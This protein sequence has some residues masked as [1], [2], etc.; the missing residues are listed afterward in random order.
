[1]NIRQTTLSTAVALAVLFQALISYELYRVYQ[2]KNKSK[3]INTGI[4]ASSIL[5]KAIIEMSL[6]RSVMQVT[7]NLDDPIAPEFRDLLNGQREKSDAGFDEVDA[8][9]SQSE[10]FRRQDEFLSSLRELR[11]SIE[12]IREQADAALGKTRQQ[13]SPQKINNL[14]N[15]MKGTIL[16]LSVLPLKLRPEDANVPTLVTTLEKIQRDAWA[17][18][19]FGGRERTYFA[20]ATATGRTFTPDTLKEMSNYHSKALT[21]M[22]SLALLGNYVGI[23][24]ELKSQIQKV[25]DVYF[26]SYNDVRMA[27]LQ[28][29]SL[30]AP[31]SSSF[32]DFF[33]V[34][35]EALDTAVNLSYMAGDEMEAYVETQAD[36]STQLFWVFVLILVAALA[37]CG[38]QIYITQY[39]VSNRI[40]KLASFM[41]RLTA[42][43]TDIDLSSVQAKDEIGEMADHVEVFRKNAIEVQRLEQEKAAQEQKAQEEKKQ[44]ATDLANRF[45]QEVGAIVQSVQNAATNMNDMSSNLTI[46]I[47]EASKQSASVAS[48][49]QETSTN[50]QTVASAAEEMSVSIREISSSIAETAAKAQQCSKSAELSQEQLQ[51]L[52]AAVDEID[53]VIQ[54]INDVAEQTNLLALN[55]TIEAARAGEAGKGFAVVASEVKSLANETHKM[56]EEISK[57]VETIK[58]TAS[59]T[60]QSVT[61]IIEEINAVDEKTSSIAAAIEQQSSATGEISS[62]AAQ[63][64]SGTSNVSQNIEE[65]QKATN[66]SAESTEQ[67]QSASHD[68]SSQASN[69]KTAVDGFLKSIRN[70]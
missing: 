60:I 44:S 18:R 19:E 7:L 35:T 43:D 20:I 58:D 26:G 47:Q 48:A 25:Q 59:H 21:A 8:L 29:S 30:G 15:N 41:K 39:R 67:L 66:E 9:V 68:L 10:N 69:L 37:L 57:K 12:T 62:S 34:S 3:E 23:N 5:N 17:I 38:F 36:K 28:E 27:L 49:S 45:E 55:A 64:A 61:S 70:S 50:V 40:V 11:T 53:S 54:S 63:A 52:R 2:E 6:E 14:P 22:Q 4:Q 24:N 1:M 32:S 46:A 56:T 42:G 31:Y 65:V 33:T 13:R 51:D 16:N